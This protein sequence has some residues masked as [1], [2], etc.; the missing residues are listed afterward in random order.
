MNRLMHRRRFL[1][2]AATT[3][4]FPRLSHA[5]EAGRIR[6]GMIGTAHSHATGKMESLRA[7]PQLF[8]IA[9]VAEPDAARRAGAE[10]LPAFAGLPWKTEDELLGD[11]TVRAIAIET[12]IA[13]APGA[14]LRAI[15]AGRHV[16]L[17]KPGAL[18]HAEFAAL[19]TEAERAGVTVQM[20]YMLR[21]NPAFELLIRAVREGWLGEITELDASMGK[22]AG[23]EQREALREYP[24]GGMFELG[25]HLVDAAVT[26][27][28][29]PAAVHAFSKSMRGDL[30]D[31]QLA[32]LEYPKL[33]AVLRCNHAD[34][35][36][37]PRR[38]LAVAGTRGAM[39]LAP[40]ESGRATLLLAD[41]RGGYEKGENRIALKLPATR[42]EEEF[43][44]LAAII[45]GEK[46][47]SWDAAHD[48]AVHAAAL[49]AAG[50]AP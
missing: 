20:G 2:A 48:I 43:R 33:A 44:D 6:I 19:R 39:E 41:A 3:A 16:H 36:G 1:A 32:V 15:R 37:F 47:P 28:G 11:A 27:L 18:T 7:L 25:C 26:L 31:N 34:P 10:K 24:G 8:E 9:G 13:D 17:D 4:M 5:A 38:R 50:V 14:A 46:R 35:H 30:P 29:P 22:L 23:D 45:H 49:R 42:Y 12:A 40:L 21:Y